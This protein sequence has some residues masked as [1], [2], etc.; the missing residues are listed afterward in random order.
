[1]GR[2]TPRG[3]CMQRPYGGCHA[4]SSSAAHQVVARELVVPW[5][6]HLLLE[7]HWVEDIH[8]ACASMR[9]NQHS[10][11]TQLHQPEAKDHSQVRL[12]AQ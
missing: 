4:C 7:P 12:N 5:A 6:S 8:A 3:Y 2:C 1:M 10:V 9:L 11:R